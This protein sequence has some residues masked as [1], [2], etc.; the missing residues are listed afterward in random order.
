MTED[1]FEVMRRTLLMFDADEASRSAKR[2]L[3]EGVDVKEVIDALTQALKEV[4]DRFDKGEIFLMHLVSAGMAA[5]VALT[6]VLEPELQKSGGKRVSLGKVVIGTVSGDI[7]DIGKSIVS[8]M[9]FVA[10]F[11]VYDLGTDVPTDD[12]VKKVKE[13]QADILGLSSLLSTTMPVQRDVIRAL[14]AAGLRDRVKVI[15]GGAP[16]TKEWAE[17]IGA[18]SYAEDATEAVR[19]AKRLI[20]VE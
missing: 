8:S 17:E 11:E 15:V 13:V 16:T 10:G 12:F 20:G 5:K 2:L 7:H 6:E 4:G 3:D 1:V 9:L 19:V 14:K 18:D